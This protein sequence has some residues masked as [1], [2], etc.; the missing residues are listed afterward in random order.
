MN[1]QYTPQ[2][3]EFM[4]KKRK[5]T[6][7]VEEVTSNN[8]DFEITELHVHLIDTKSAEIFKKKKGYYPIATA[9]GEVLFPPFHLKLD[10]TIVFG[11]KSFLGIKYLSYTGIQ[12]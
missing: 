5:T 8:S 10:D 4:Q 6:I 9:E 2:L 7:V 11:L 3:L 12:K 1:I